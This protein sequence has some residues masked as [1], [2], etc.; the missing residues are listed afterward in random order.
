[1]ECAAQG[2]AVVK[3]EGKKKRDDRVGFLFPSL[4]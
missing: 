4:G 1:M 3:I 2:E